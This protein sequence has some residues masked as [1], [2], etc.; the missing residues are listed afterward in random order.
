LRLPWRAE[1]IEKL[2][3][4]VS[5][6]LANHIAL[7]IRDVAIREKLLVKGNNLR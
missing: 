7:T 3:F 6:Q 4:F 5:Q 1:K 2:G